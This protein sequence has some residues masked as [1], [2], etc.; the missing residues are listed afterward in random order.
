M[1]PFQSAD[2]VSVP[3][4]KLNLPSDNQSSDL[5]TSLWKDMPQL[6]PSA[7]RGDQLAQSGNSLDF[8]TT[9]IFNRKAD[10]G[11]GDDPGFI[12]GVIAEKPG[13]IED[14][15]FIPGV[16]DERPGTIGDPGFIPGVIDQLPPFVPGVIEDPGFIPGVIDER[17]GIINDPGFI[18][19]V[20]D[21]LPGKQVRA[22]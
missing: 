12:P 11:I 6:Q 4:E 5:S 21:N 8:G 22:L 15:G 18:P 7:F 16:I 20:I 14:P 13:V 3:V 1:P 19:S 10:K 2:D 9:D 17:P